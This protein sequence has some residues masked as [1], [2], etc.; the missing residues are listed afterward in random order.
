MR[1]LGIIPA[2]G[3]S[4]GV[5]R[6]NLKILGNKP[7][8]AHTFDQAKKSK[9][10]T[11]IILS[12]EDEEIIQWAQTNG[13][14]VPFIRPSELATDTASSID[15]VVHAISFLENL[16]RTYDAVCLLQPTS[17]FREDKMIDKAIEKFSNDS[18]DALIS[19]LKIPQEF[20]PHWA[21]EKDQFGLLKIATG[22]KEIIKRRQELPDAY[23]RDGSIYITRTKILLENHSFYGNK[24]GFIESNAEYYCNIDT[25]KDWKLAE[26]LY[27]D[28]LKSKNI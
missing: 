5:L 11:D 20:N 25:E 12:S 17:P 6:K 1:I 14:E 2:R 26:L 21:F 13:L 15:V 4:K 18:S 8:I 23:Y 10:L 22:D 16:G 3:G 7:L 9:L 28:L 24:L 19:V 27:S